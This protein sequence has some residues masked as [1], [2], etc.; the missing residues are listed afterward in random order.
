M[1]ENLYTAGIFAKK[2]GV[3]IRTIRFYDKENLLKPSSYSE[4]GYRLYTDS[5]F[6]K[7]QKILTLKYLGFSLA[8]IKDTINAENNQDSLKSS[9]EMQKEIMHNKINHMKLVARAISD[10]KDMINENQ[11]LDWDKIIDIIRV[12]NTE[13]NIL[14]QYRNSSNLVKRIS[15]HD[16]YS[17]NN[18]GWYRWMFNKFKLS[19]DI[20]V[21][22]IGCGNAMMWRRNISYIPE[23]CEITLTDISEGMLNDA[24]DNLKEEA[25]KFKFKLVD[26]SNIPFKDESFNII[27]ANHMLF[28][29]RDRERVFSEIKRV[30]KTGGFFYC[31]T[32]GESHM[33]E[34]EL[35]IK[36]FDKSFVMSESDLPREFGLE[37]GKS[38]LSSWFQDI[39]RYDYED[40]LVVTGSKALIEYVYSTHGNVNEVLKDRH[41]EFEDYIKEEMLKSGNI[42]ITKSSGL[43]ESRKL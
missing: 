32:V 34:L 42:F 43:F 9:L 29:C 12:I 14:N 15:I 17:T 24:K 36:N 1:K 6:A 3:T 5:D 2:A 26:A 19:Q 37:N 30:L 33:K 21:L 35:L 27:I 18:T 10:A 38:Q 28:Y 11:Q 7:L 20:K 39:K 23:N 25:E 41:K 40:N 31:S 16:K 13:K 4:S 8:G 22:E